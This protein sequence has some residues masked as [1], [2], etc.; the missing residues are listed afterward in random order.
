MWNVTTQV[1]EIM[2]RGSGC[3]SV[4]SIMTSF[5]LCSAQLA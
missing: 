2:L 4:E 1:A 3:L 5:T